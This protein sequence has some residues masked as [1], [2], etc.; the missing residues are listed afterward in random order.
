V[1]PGET[2]V[3]VG[4]SEMESTAGVTLTELVAVLFVETGSGVAE[5]T[6]ME[7]AM[8]VLPGVVDA[9]VN[10]RVKL[11]FDPLVKAAESVQVSVPVDPET[12]LVQVQLPF[13]LVTDVKLVVLAG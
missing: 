4:V 11:A 5:L 9:T 3:G 13:G 8:A 12:E 1:P 2:V 10:T 7:P 6:V